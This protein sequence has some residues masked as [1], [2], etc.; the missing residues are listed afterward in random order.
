MMPSLPIGDRPVNS[1][2]VT[3][4]TG[5][6]HLWFTTAAWACGEIAMASRAETPAMS[7]DLEVIF[8][9]SFGRAPGPITYCDAKGH[10][11]TC[12]RKSAGRA[13]RANRCSL[14]ANRTCRI[15]GLSFA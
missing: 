1:V 13:V 6:P 5:A 4:L 14:Q 9:S 2:L 10:T 8:A 12:V 15:T 7:I 11:I 3:L